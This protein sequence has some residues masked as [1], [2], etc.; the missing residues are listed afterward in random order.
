MKHTLLAVFLLSCGGDPAKDTLV[1]S[2]GPE[3]GSPGPT[4]RP[5][6]PCLTCHDF[7]VGGTVYLQQGKPDPLVAAQID[8][9][10]LGGSVACTT[11]TNAAGNFY[12][13]QKECVMPM[14]AKARI[15][16][17]SPD[18]KM[19]P[20]VAEMVTRI[21]RDGSCATCHH[22]DMLSPTSVEKIYLLTSDQP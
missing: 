21:G 13:K 17:P 14:P 11:T 12:L 7:A 5:G 20:D 2:L 10:D 9:L 15:T 4:H 22:G 1:K 18:P 3:N 16:R 8:I 19:M 6:Q